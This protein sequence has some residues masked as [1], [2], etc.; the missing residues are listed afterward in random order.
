MLEFRL[1]GDAARGRVADRPE[2]WR[3]ARGLVVGVTADAVKSAWNE[4]LTD[5]QHTTFS[6]SGRI[7][8][9]QPRWAGSA[10]MTLADAQF[11]AAI[12]RRTV[13]ENL[14]T[15]LGGDAVTVT[16]QLSLHDDVLEMGCHA[17]APVPRFL[18][19]PVAPIEVCGVVEGNPGPNA[20]VVTL[21]AGV[22]VVR[23][24]RTGKLAEVLGTLLPG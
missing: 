2:G 21:E 20:F 19:R 4:L 23:L 12:D 16:G 9:E 15:T 8:T 11:A 18:L 3:R 22:V 24:G 14:T 7:I 10:K 17:T 13:E 1:A 6:G 5:R